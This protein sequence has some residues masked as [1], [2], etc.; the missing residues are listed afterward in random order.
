MKKNEETQYLNENPNL[1]NEDSSIKQKNTYSNEDK[2]IR[3]KYSSAGASV[4]IEGEDIE[5]KTGLKCGYPRCIDIFKDD[6]IIRIYTVSPYEENLGNYLLD[7]NYLDYSETLQL[8]NE[9]ILTR[10]NRVAN[11][12][13][14]EDGSFAVSIYYIDKNT[15]ISNPYKN[16]DIGYLFGYYLPAQYKDNL[17]K[18]N[19]PYY[20]FSY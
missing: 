3:F 11:M 10:V 1:I 18:L 14:N 7:D 20:C 13:V 8:S 6:L 15:L 17:D 12:Q 5:T 4:S 16:G 2:K 9:T 19:D